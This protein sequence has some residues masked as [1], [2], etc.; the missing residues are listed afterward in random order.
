MSLMTLRELARW[1]RQKYRWHLH[2]AR[3]RTVYDTRGPDEAWHHAEDAAF[4]WEARKEILASIREREL[5]WAAVDSLGMTGT[6]T[7]SMHD[8]TFLEGRC[9]FGAT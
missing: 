6:A 9:P 4:H 2:T 8:F 5:A 7:L 3:M 1:H